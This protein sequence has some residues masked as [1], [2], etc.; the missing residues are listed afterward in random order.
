MISLLCAV[1]LQAPT[2]TQVWSIRLQTE[3][4][5]LGVGEQ[6]VYFGTNDS[7]GALDQATGKKIWSKNL[8]SPQLGAF[9]AEGEGKVFASI[10][11]GALWAYDA[12]TGKQAW[13]A[14]RDGF[15]SPIAFYN[16]AV[17][18]ETS[19][20]KFSAL[21]PANG[22][23][24]WTADMAG[25]SVSAKPMRIGRAILVGT[26]LG[27]VW[28]FDKDSGKPIWHFDK[29][30]AKTQSIVLGEDRAYAFFD[31]GAVVALSLETGQKVWAFY[32]N[33]G[34]F[35]TPLS[36]DGRLFVTSV[37]GNFFSIAALNG[38]ELWR[39]P[40]SYRQNFGLSQPLPWRDGY[41]VT[42]RTKLVYLNDQGDKQWEFDLKEDLFGQQPRALGNDLLL[43]GSHAIMRYRVGP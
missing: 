1:L 27:T 36:K 28:A 9:V 5:S 7:F 8:T 34:L 24:L 10:G 16:Q 26:K 23:P 22:K 11:Q 3:I 4:Q 6:A 37:G 21:N 2:F 29:K 25:A 13:M 15:A 18:A 14:K 30:N 42:D 32:T 19:L 33:N 39:K 40:L 35:G 12:K 41:L 17:Y 31:D 20:G 38:Q 43:R